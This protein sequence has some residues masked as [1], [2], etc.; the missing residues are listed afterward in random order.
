VA[1][2]KNAQQIAAEAVF[3]YEARLQ[4]K[5]FRWIAEQLGVGLP[6]AHRRVSQEL[7]RR[8]SPLVEE[9]RK[10]ES[11]RIDALSEIAWKIATNPTLDPETRLKAIDRAERLSEQQSRL[12]GAYAPTRSVVAQVGDDADPEMTDLLAQARAEIAAERRA[13]EGT[14]DVEDR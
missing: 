6:T 11:D 9:V 8:V 12:Y 14:D 5:S 10:L 2:R 7:E 13:T 4:H 3:A 1:E